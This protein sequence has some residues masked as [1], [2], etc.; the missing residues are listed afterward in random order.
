M[1]QKN[2]AAFYIENIFFYFY[3]IFFILIDREV[4]NP[5]EKPRAW[6]DNEIKIF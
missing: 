1:I 4:W 3:M 6:N 2:S 5:H